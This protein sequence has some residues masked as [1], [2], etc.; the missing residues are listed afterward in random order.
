[1]YSVVG[2]PDCGALKLV[3]DR[4]E[5]TQ[6]PRCGRRTKFKKLHKFFQS[7]DADAAREVRARLLADRGGQ[8]DAYEDL[9]T[10][11]QL[12]TD[13]E[14]AGV[15]DVEYLEASSVDPGEV[16]DVVVERARSGLRGQAAL[17]EARWDRTRF[18]R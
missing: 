15:D 14:S 11:A 3:A 2:C 7:E 9:G 17:P 1:M 12:G 8:R 4:P 18:P 13:A 6:C 16:V 10:F 5:T